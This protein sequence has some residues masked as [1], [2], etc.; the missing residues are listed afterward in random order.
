MPEKTAL[1]MIE[2]VRLSGNNIT[3]PDNIYGYG[4]PDFIKALT[5]NITR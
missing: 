3:H 5:D 4:T 1:E 2:I